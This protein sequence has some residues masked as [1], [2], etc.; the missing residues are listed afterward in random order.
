[1]I[2]INLDEFNWG[3]NPPAEGFDPNAR[4]LNLKD[5]E[6]GILICCAFGGDPLMNL[7]LEMSLGLSADQK[8][9]VSER[10]L[11]MTEADIPGAPDEPEPTGA[12]GIEPS[13]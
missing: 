2:R 8:K 7:V 10:M 13:D 5:L 3:T 12:L 6:S 1:M 11:V 4:I 9:H